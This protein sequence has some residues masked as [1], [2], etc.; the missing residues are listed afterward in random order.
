MKQKNRLVQRFM[1]GI[2]CLVLGFLVA[3]VVNSNHQ[4]TER[5]TRDTWEIRTSLLE[6]QQAQ[7]ELYKEIEEAENTLRQY[8]ESTEHQQIDSLK[9]SIEQLREQAGLIE[10]QGSGVVVTLQPLFLDEESQ[11]YPSIN[12]ELLQLLINELN[13][14]GASEIAIENQRVIN[15]TPI[16]DVNDNI[17][18]N[19]SSIGDLPIEITILTDNPEQLINQV[20][21]SEIGDYFALENVTISIE[22]KNEV[23]LPAY[24]DQIDLHHIDIVDVTEEGEE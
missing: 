8:K 11:E 13:T 7:Q 3:I 12:A 22:A 24:D 1:V 17:Y 6:E 9:Q 19:N 16:R 2:V 15:I 14:A 21:V 18:V 20:E 10:I 23:S 5:D 4:A